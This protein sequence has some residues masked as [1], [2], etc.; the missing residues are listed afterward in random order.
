ML[1]RGTAAAPPA[2]QL[3]ADILAEP[4]TF[5]AEGQLTDTAR[6]RISDIL[7]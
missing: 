5:N 6:Q 2:R 1:G 3:I 4:N 7:A